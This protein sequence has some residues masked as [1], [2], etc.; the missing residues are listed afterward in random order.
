MTRNS[1]E[2]AFE[3][4]LCVTQNRTVRECEAK[5]SR[6]WTGGTVITAELIRSWIAA[7]EARGRRG[8]SGSR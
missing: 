7:Q 4:G 5:F 1:R 2:R 3:F 8:A 6:L